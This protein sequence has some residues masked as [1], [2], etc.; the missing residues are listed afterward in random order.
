MN[1]DKNLDWFQTDHVKILNYLDKK[2]DRSKKTT[3]S[4]LFILTGLKEYQTEMNSIMKKVNDIHK[5]QKM[6]TKQEDDWIS[7][8]RIKTKY[9]ALHLDAIS[10]L[11]KKK[12]LNENVM[13][14]F[15]LMSFLSGIL[16]P[17]RRSLDFSEL[18]IRN[19][20]VKTD[21]Y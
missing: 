11:N 16:I 15:L 9:D 12:I 19:F 17:P 14:E 2:N 10:M 8:D 18:K 1:G 13:M 4:A 21:N 5:D 3:L 6:N 7:I 20:D